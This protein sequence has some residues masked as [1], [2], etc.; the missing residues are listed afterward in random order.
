MNEPTPQVKTGIP[1]PIK[2]KVIKIRAYTPI[3]G[4]EHLVAELKDYYLKE[5][6]VGRTD[7]NQIFRDF[8]EM[9][10]AERN[11]WF[12]PAQAQLTNWKKKW[13]KSLPI[14]VR[15]IVL[16]QKDVIENMKDE[17]LHIKEIAYHDLED[18]AKNLQ[19]MLIEDAEN[20]LAESRE[21]YQGI[22]ENGGMLGKEAYEKLRLKRKEIALSI[23]KEV[24]SGVHKHELIKIKK[25]KEGRETAGFHLD[26]VKSATSGELSDVD[27]ELLEQ[28]VGSHA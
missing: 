5:R 20:L 22:D 6:K 7:Q 26:L 4:M 2:E 17:K 23:S 28:G 18:G 11:I 19:Q 21:E 12:N 3:T 8:R 13:E 27:L 1:E 25:N 15:K 14:H 9:C 24:L 16:K 10:K